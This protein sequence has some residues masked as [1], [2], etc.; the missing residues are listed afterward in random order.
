[1]VLK[2]VLTICSIILSIILFC[3]DSILAQME[4]MSR[5]KNVNIP[6]SLKIKDQILEK[7]AYDLDFCR[8]SNPPAF[9]VRIMKRGT[10]LDL[11]QGEVFPYDTTED[12]NIPNKPT[13]KMT[14]DQS[15]KLLILVF[16][17]GTL[18][19]SCPKARTKFKISYEE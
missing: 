10:F 1:M 13:L 3:P 11:V 2:R 15:E 16:E 17:S 9:F 14:R 12:R 8:T 4:P 6:V 18:M 19:R 5:F 7:G